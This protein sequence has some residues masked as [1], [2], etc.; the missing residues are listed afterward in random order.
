M[1]LHVS[2]LWVKQWAARSRWFRKPHFAITK[3]KCYENIPHRRLS[4]VA[5]ISASKDTFTPVYSLLSNQ[6]INHMTVAS[7]YL[8]VWSWS[9]QSPELQ[10]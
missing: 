9:G 1:K 4:Y 3:K 5:F 6:P 2:N 10:N 7:M 8:G